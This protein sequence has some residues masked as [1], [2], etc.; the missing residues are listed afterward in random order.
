MTFDFWWE[1]SICKSV[2][3]RSANKNEPTAFKQGEVRNFYTI[4]WIVLLIK[5]TLWHCW[6]GAHFC[7][8]IVRFPIYFNKAFNFFS[9][10][11]SLCVFRWTRENNESKSHSKSIFINDK[12]KKEECLWNDQKT[13]LLPCQRWAM[14]ANA[15]CSHFF[16]STSTKVPAV[17]M[18]HKRLLMKLC[19]KLWREKKWIIKGLCRF[20]LRSATKAFVNLISSRSLTSKNQ[21]GIKSEGGC[22]A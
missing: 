20:E 13:I 18:A 5:S 4:F 11:F 7:F 21:W 22:K 3:R 8:V 14:I 12:M 15:N 1:S 10:N 19:E 9:V 17:L 6:N 2:S 16:I